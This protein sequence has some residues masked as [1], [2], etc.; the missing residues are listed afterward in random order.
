[1]AYNYNELSAVTYNNGFTVW[2][3]RTN[4]EWNDVRRPAYWNDAMMLLRPGDAIYF[5][6]R[7]FGIAFYPTA[8]VHQAP[9]GGFYFQ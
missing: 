2:H 3:Y 6:C 4:D 5:Q 8:R 7:N 9:D 1:M